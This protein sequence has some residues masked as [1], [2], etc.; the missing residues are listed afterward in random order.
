MKEDIS[1]GKLK[2]GERLP[3]EKKYCAKNGALVKL[4]PKRQWRS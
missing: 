2:E 4:R 3:S 1:V